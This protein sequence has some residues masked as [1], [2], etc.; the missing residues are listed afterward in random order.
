MMFY[1]AGPAFA[2]EAEGLFLTFR[3]PDWVVTAPALELASAAIAGIDNPSIQIQTNPVT[4]MLCKLRFIVTS[5]L[6]NWDGLDCNRI[7]ICLQAVNI[8]NR[9]E[10]VLRPAPDRLQ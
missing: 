6:Q 2:D 4:R 9:K 5:C 1:T 7:V 10:P 3:Y 8:P